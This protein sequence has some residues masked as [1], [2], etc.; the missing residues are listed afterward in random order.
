M[1][2]GPSQW[3]GERYVLDVLF[4]DPPNP[5][6]PNAGEVEPNV[7]G[8]NLT[9]RQRLDQHRVIEACANCH[10]RLDPYGF[11]M[12]NFNVIGLWRTKQDGERGYWPDTAVI[13][14]SGTFPSGHKF[15]DFKGYKAGL[16]AMSDRFLRG[17]SEKMLIYALGRSIEVLDRGTVDDLVKT[18]KNNDHTLRSLIK[19]VVMSD[20]F[21]TK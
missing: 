4:N 19:G 9:V 15:E 13:D 21:L 16:T 5:P 3:N 14:P 1:A 17:F 11:G 7:Q 10:S 2:T 12:E 18:L 6:P 8:G 20:A